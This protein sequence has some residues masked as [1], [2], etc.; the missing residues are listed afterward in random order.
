MIELETALTYAKDNIP[1]AIDINQDSP[2]KPTNIK[3]FNHA[4][5]G[6]LEEALM[7]NGRILW[8]PNIKSLNGAIIK[9]PQSQ[10][11]FCNEIYDCV[12]IGGIIQ[13]KEGQNHIF[14]AHVY[15]SILRLQMKSIIDEILK[16]GLKP[17]KVIYSPREDTLSWEKGQKVLE[18]YF[19][20][21]ITVLRN[22]EN[23]AEMIVGIG[24]LI[25]NNKF[26]KLG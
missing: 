2:E 19:S 9:N 5:P 23:Q 14:G 21:T 16:C 11:I 7:I 18:N 8:F 22:K 3:L 17:K 24:G 26:Y 10:Y 15:E 4:I 13:D 20:E 25:L 12:A 6:S 1:K